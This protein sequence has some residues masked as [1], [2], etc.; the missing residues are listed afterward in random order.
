LQSGTA[1]FVIYKIH[2]EGGEIV[3]YNIDFA[4]AFR[5]N[6]PE[7]NI[8]AAGFPNNSATKPNSFRD[9]L[10]EA[11]RS[12]SQDESRR[13]DSIAL[14]KEMIGRSEEKLKSVKKPER[15][16]EKNVTSEAESKKKKPDKIVAALEEILSKLEELA[17]LQQLGDIPEDKQT[18]LLENIRE[19]LAEL[20]A[21]ADMSMMPEG[22]KLA[23]ALEGMLGELKSNGSMEGTALADFAKQLEAMA[24][25]ISEKY[26]G[27]SEHKA[28]EAAELPIG[29]ETGKVNAATDNQDVE[30]VEGVSKLKVLNSENKDNPEAGSST[31]EKASEGQNEKM[32]TEASVSE[33]KLTN[34]QVQPAAEE[35]I[36]AAL[37][38]KVQKVTDEAGKGKESRGQDA[39]DNKEAAET[40]VVPKIVN[41]TQQKPFNEE[42]TVIK[43]EQTIADNGLETVQNQTSP[44]KTQ[45]L[46]RAEVISQIVKK[47]ELVITDSQPEM[48]MQLEPENLGK[49]TL[50][51]AV[52]K[53]LITAK[54]VAESYQ[55]K[56]IIES[57]FNELKDM[58]QEKGLGVQNF[59]VS[60]SQDNEEYNNSSTFQQWKETIR[61]NGKRM[62]R[63]GSYAGYLE[64]EGM[65]ARAVNP[66]SIHSGEFDH[67]A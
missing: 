65:T 29:L 26:A 9:S 37:D 52:E 31:T 4:T 25:E 63:G 39:E 11:V 15:N 64:G 46:N 3:A 6:T 57:N 5:A 22:L 7:N 1:A 60:V 12:G 27:V 36:K 40:E 34:K 14:R 59:S 45:T 49:L 2:W 19:A 20:T 33:E 67:K 53:G 30:G 38:G 18:V 44:P 32:K 47:A 21:A 51:I 41:T 66:Y 24:S 50:K 62:D 48:R 42:I 43:Q 17:K 56:Q 10:K 28:N 54:F 23:G 55:V 35:D 8:K 58:L 13:P 61:L 16:D